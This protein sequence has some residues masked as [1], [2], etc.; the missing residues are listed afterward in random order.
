M[1]LFA[2][3]G[4]FP[5][6]CLAVGLAMFAVSYTMLGEGSKDE[7]AKAPE[8][9][10]VA[11]EMMFKAILEDDVERL[12]EALAGGAD[13]NTFNDD[14]IS[15]LQVA[16]LGSG[17]AKTVYGQVK[18]LLA[19]GADPNR[20][21]EDG[22]TPLHYAADFG[23]SDAVVS[24]LI[25]AGANPDLPDGT[26]T[27]PL[28]LALFTGNQGAVTALEKATTVRPGNYQILKVL[29]VAS[30]WLED[31][32]IDADSAK[33]KAEAVSQWVQKLQSE[34]L[35][36]AE[37][38]TIVFDAVSERVADSDSEDCQTCDEGGE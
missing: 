22:K 6:L 15:A 14:G 3:R 30:K 34:G 27:T 32:L 29:G 8:S 1:K 19:A 35:L 4:A 36:T 24:S 7:G 9:S 23:G 13:P 12:E 38:A 31:T 21:D 26:G 2:S 16:I 5:L 28:Q 11:N 18:A 17:G 37:E 10:T 25:G 33:E 20:T